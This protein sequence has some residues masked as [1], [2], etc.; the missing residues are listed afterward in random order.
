M[1]LDKADEA[2]HPPVGDD[3]LVDARRSRQLC[4]GWM[5]TAA[6]TPQVS[7]ERFKSTNLSVESA[8]V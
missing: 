1:P 6:K 2:R 7:E 4:R 8:A 3:P 5:L